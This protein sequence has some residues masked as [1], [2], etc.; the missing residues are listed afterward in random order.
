MLLNLI[1][2][3]YHFVVE[4]F[5]PRFCWRRLLCW[6]EISAAVYEILFCW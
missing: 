1:Y 3:G 6:K 4:A 2:V 5:V